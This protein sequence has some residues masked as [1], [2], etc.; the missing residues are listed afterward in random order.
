MAKEP[1][2]PAAYAALAYVLSENWLGVEALEQI[3]KAV[4]LAPKNVFLWHELARLYSGSYSYPESLKIPKVRTAIETVRKLDP[5]FVPV[6]DMVVSDLVNDDLLRDAV[7]EL[8]RIIT[9]KPGAFWAQEMAADIFR[10]K[11]W[12][13]EHVGR[14]RA[15]EKAFPTWERINRFWCDYYRRNDNEAKA[16]RFRDMA[17]ER[18]RSLKFY[19]QDRIEQALQ[20]GNF[21]A[22]FDYYRKEL[23]KHPDNYGTL[24][25]IADLHLTR[26]QY[27]EA[28]SA[29]EEIIRIFPEDEYYYRQVGRIYHEWGKMEKALKYYRKSLKLEPGDDSLRRYIKYLE[30]GE[31]DKF[32]RDY[33]LD[34][35][36]VKKCVTETPAPADLAGASAVV[37]LRENVIRGYSKG[38]S[39]EYTH[40][41]VKI[42]DKKGI[43]LYKVP[44]VRGEIEFF[45][46]RNPDGSIIEA[47]LIAGI[48]RLPGLVIGSIVEYAYRG[49]SP[50]PRYSGFVSGPHFLL[51][52][53]N[54]IDY[55]VIV[56]PIKRLR[57]VAVI[58]KELDPLPPIM[59]NFENYNILYSDGVSADNTAFIYKW[60]ARDLPK[61][62]PE[63]N[64]PTDREWM[65]YVEIRGKNQ[66][67]WEDIGA[68][69]A[70]SNYGGHRVTA[71]IQKTADKVV[72][73]ISDDAARARALYT[74]VLETI[75]TEFGE[76]EAHNVL[77]TKT[78]SRAQ[79]FLA[80][81]RAANVPFDFLY[82]TVD[83]R[84]VP[85]LDWSLPSVDI[86]R[87][88]R[89]FR[90]R[91]KG[92]P[93]EYVSFPPGIDKFPYGKVPTFFQGGY[94]HTTDIGPESEKL[95]V[96]PIEERALHLSEATFFFNSMEVKGSL[97]QPQARAYRFKQQVLETETRARWQ[98]IA[99]FV[100]Q[101]F[102]GAALTDFDFPDI[103][104]LNSPF[105]FNFKAKLSETY[106]SKQGKD[107]RTCPIGFSP[108]RLCQ[109]LQLVP[110]R[111]FPLAFRFEL[112]ARD[113]AVFYPPEGYKFGIIPD[114]ISVAGKPFRLEVS[115][116]KKKDG[117]LC[118][119]RK[120]DIDPQIVPID[121]YKDFVSFCKQVDDVDKT[122]IVFIKDVKDIPDPPKKEDPKKEEEKDGPVKEEPK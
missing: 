60:E 121:D 46:A 110:D 63:R 32:W 6:I 100:G 16:D 82:V 43:E 77:L 81:L 19:E 2:N 17:Y 88:A 66:V 65:P 112:I 35:E 70:D 104:D 47:D 10:N 30:T 120:L 83:P 31:D 96:A 102:P 57:F 41:V 94:I 105:K 72:R 28:I 44:M 68:E 103:E 45:H 67:T 27:P 8:D 3:E 12:M 76:P 20:S 114:N 25:R 14:W 18:D 90:I 7:K 21:K 80:L 98:F 49:G 73:E 23:Q 1:E 53:P 97:T 101:E 107:R 95:P 36:E 38:S 4:E 9:K 33:V 34:E 92:G 111:K 52:M 64:M 55:D 62:E 13:A 37:L 56:Q 117:S 42:L 93:A 24:S 54:N 75:K 59:R 78:G 15:I 11:G 85:P 109:A 118:V 40:E 106:L 91:P 50:F 39:D 51:D 26:G 89:M 74:Y 61:Y 99:Q 122:K 69:L 108:I 71:L 113:K 29:L 115:F 116:T 119:E 84:L 87:G 22:A 48:Y 79:L 86:F 58:D 5:E